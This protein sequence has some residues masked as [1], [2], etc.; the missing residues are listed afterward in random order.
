MGETVKHWVNDRKQAGEFRWL[1]HS[2]SP[3][4]QTGYGN[5]TGLFTERM[6]RGGFQVGLS[7]FCGR[8]GAPAVTHYGMLELPRYMDTYGND[9]LGAHALWSE[10]DVVLYLLDPFVVEQAVVGAFPSAWWV[11]NDCAPV[12]PENKA[13]LDHARWLWAMSR[14]GE[15]EL[16]KAF[17]RDRV[18]YVPHGIDTKAFHPVDRAEARKRVSDWL[19]RDLD[20]H[21]LV[22]SVAAN[23]GTP[24]RKNFW[25]MLKAFAQL[26]AE[27]ESALFYIHTEKHGRMNGDHL[28]MMIEKM[29]LTGRVVFPPEYNL[30]M[31]M[32]GTERLNDIYNMADVF[33]LLSYGEGFG[34]PIVEA[35]AAGCPVILTDG[36]A[37]TEL[38]FSGELIP[39]TECQPFYGR[40][41]CVWWQA[42]I[43]KAGAALI[44]SKGWG[45]A[46][47]KK[48]RQGALAYDADYVFE[49]Y[50]KPAMQ[51]IQATIISQNDPAAWY[52]TG[53]WEDGWIHLPSRD[54]ASDKALA[55]HQDG[56][57]KI[58]GGWGMAAAGVDL[59]IEENPQGGTAKIVCREIV[60]SYGLD[61]LTFV[62][63]DVVIDIG[64][65]VGVVSCW[66]AKRWPNIRVY[67]F[68]PV[69]ENF[70]YLERN[71]EANGL[72]NVT[73]VNAA[74]TGDGRDVVLYGDTDQ[75]AGGTNMFG[76]QVIGRQISTT[77]GEILGVDKIE[78]VALLKLDCEGAEY[79]IAADQ[80]SLAKVD[81]VVAEI[82]TNEAFVRRYGTPEMLME[83]LSAQVI[84][85]DC[86]VV[87]VPDSTPDV[88]VIIP[89][90]NGEKTLKRAV[91][92]ALSQPNVEV[93]VVDDG[94]TDG[95]AELLASFPEIRVITHDSNL[96][97]VPAMNAGLKA[98]K[99]RYILFHGDDDWLEDG[100]LAALVKV[101][102]AAPETV[103]FAYGHLQ[104]HGRRT[105]LVQARPYVRGDYD[106]FFPA[107]TGLIW[108]RELAERHGLAY[109]TL[110]DGKTAHAEDFD[111][112]KQIIAAGY[113]G[114]AVD[115]L[116]IHYTLAAGR[117]TAW[118]HDNQDEV[119][120]LWKERWPEFEGAL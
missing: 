48:A 41:G 50:M 119:L 105:D 114:L 25:G 82:H 38:C 76:G 59:D 45:D 113:D 74:V 85:V 102:D 42:D 86:S 87:V 80:D 117:A 51:Q 31:G 63:G 26:A 106:R 34:I 44:A 109:R 112:V 40:A 36:S 67:A 8:E 39:A 107:G 27:D 54:K 60:D 88:S 94:S 95:T 103:G 6:V 116:V 72:S 93:I 65:N 28:P 52:P 49:T 61:K 98:A 99:G 15:R 35:Q 56:R 30:M 118:L 77:L 104:Y 19:G 32:V 100:A 78:R 23:K 29:G 92:A 1:M 11:P 2:N 3:A 111:M 89:T 84:Q 120:P 79:E 101:L 68:E 115:D 110:H 7:A 24:S 81:R 21:Y 83:M 69:R 97:Q 108:R 13:V 4:Y 16:V 71:I 37:M 17:G 20:G 47:R 22:V 55:I 62:D 75:N 46:Y 9:I 58:V 64:A 66:L 18:A 91:N 53:L 57:R 70:R 14:F 10:A 12:S 96:G 43:D 90:L 33:M 5:Q 73:A